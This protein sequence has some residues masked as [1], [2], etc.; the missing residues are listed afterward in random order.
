MLKVKKILTTSN[1]TDAQGPTRSFQHLF[2]GTQL[3]PP[4]S[5]HC[6]PAPDLDVPQAWKPDPMCVDR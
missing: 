5:S 3:Q 4:T 1:I 2:L 6:P